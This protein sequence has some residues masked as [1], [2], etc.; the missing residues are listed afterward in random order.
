MRTIIG[1]VFGSIALSTGIA[2][3]LFVMSDVLW[4]GQWGTVETTY[5]EWF[6]RLEEALARASDR[7]FSYFR[8]WLLYLGTPTSLLVM[9]WLFMARYR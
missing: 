6:F 9:S 2:S 1:F 5:F 7:E 8:V 3:S 4:V